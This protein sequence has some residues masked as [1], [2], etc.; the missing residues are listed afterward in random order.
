MVEAHSGAAG[1]ALFPEPWSHIGGHFVKAYQTAYLRSVQ[2]PIH[3]HVLVKCLL[4]INCIQW[5][6]ELFTYI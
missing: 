5:R 4:K 6:F 3:T 2:L 1:N